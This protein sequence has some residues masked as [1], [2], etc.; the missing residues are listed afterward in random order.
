MRS[1]VFNNINNALHLASICFAALLAIVPAFGFTQSGSTYTTNGSQSDVQAAVNAAPDNGSVTVVI[2]NGT[3]SWSGTLSITKALTLRGQSA[4]GVT[5]RS[6]NATSFLISATSS[7]NGHINIYWLNVIQTVDNSGD[8]NRGQLSIDRTEPSNYTVMV[9][10]CTFD[11]TTFFAYAAWVGANGVIF[12]NDNFPATGAGPTNLTGISFTCGKYGY[13]SSWNTPDTWGTQDATGLAN[14]YVEDCHFANGPSYAADCDDNSRVVWR[15]NTMQDAMVGSHG[16]DTGQYSVRQMEVYNNTFTMTGNNIQNNNNWVSFRGGS[17]VVFNNSMQDIPGKTGVQLN[18][19]SINRI[20]SIPCQTGYPAAR[21]T[22]QGWSNASNLAFGHPVVTA[23]GTGA[24]T[25]GVYVWG[26][27]G[28]ETSD[29]GYVALDQYAPG[30]CG[31]GQLITNYLIQ[32]RDYFVGVA[33]P[34]YTPYQHPHPL[35]TQFAVG[36]PTPTP[37]PTPT[38]LPTPTP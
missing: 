9:H 32:G 19:Y 6:T 34:N 33:K 7:A 8:S 18:V 23:D 29:P 24:A 35:H 17:G 10:D 37:T 1:F 20:G 22:G 13:T 28:T 3:Y 2:P 16:Q 31:N 26:N 12:W 38:P 5:I 25:E 15:Y 11:T 14:S 21:Q 4:T 30:E 27:T 36:N